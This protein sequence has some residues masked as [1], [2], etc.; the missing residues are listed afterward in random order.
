MA[1]VRPELVRMVLPTQTLPRALESGFIDRRWDLQHVINGIER[2]Q[3][4]ENSFHRQID[5]VGDDD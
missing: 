1:D 4:C 2:A 5:E 3:L